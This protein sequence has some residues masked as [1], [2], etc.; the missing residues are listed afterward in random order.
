MFKYVLKRVLIGFVTLFVLGSATFFLMKA[1]P[2]SPVN[3]E[4][5]KSKE[6]QEL[7]IIRYGLDRPVFEQYTM[8]L[9][10]LAHGDLGESYVKEGVYV[11]KTIADTFPVTAR[12]GGVAFLF[13][14][15]VGITLGTTAAL[16][17]RK[18]VNNVC[19][20]VATIG[21]SVPSFLLSM[22]L[23]II[24][25]VELRL[26]P[27]VGLRTPANYVL[28]IIALSLYPI[29]MIAR[30]TR[31]SMLEVMKQDYIILARSKGTSYK[32]VVI[33][34][35]LKNAMLPVVTYAGPAFA[36]MLT[37]SFVVETIFS[38]PGTG[39]EFV[40]NISNRDYQMIMGLTLFLGAL[41]ITFNII[42]DIV[43]AMIDPR[44]KLK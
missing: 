27:F 18:W 38:I 3:G 25:G 36:F 44:I 21:V 32:M 19:M 15:V 40:S 33:K 23:I 16:S 6:A 26:L 31:S 43:A 37:G 4:R 22:F 7:A 29:S 24:F 20:F 30:L 35:A 2:G 5:F 41:I 8:Y 34:H 10:N 12:L 1:T 13:A 39:K 28:P 11:D 17:K 9:N 42:T 14:L